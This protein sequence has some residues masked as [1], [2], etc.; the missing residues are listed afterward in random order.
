LHF[1]ADFPPLKLLLWLVIE[2]D[3]G[4]KGK[5]KGFFFMFCVVGCFGLALEPLVMV[6]SWHA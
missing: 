1:D 3:G 5:G 2:I 4:A 6:I